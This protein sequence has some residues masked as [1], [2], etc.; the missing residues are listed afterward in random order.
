MNILK[1]FRSPYVTFFLTF[2]FLFSSCSQDGFQEQDEVLSKIDSSVFA[3]ESSTY[4]KNKR[5]L[6]D[7]QISDIG[8]N[9][10]IYLGELLVKQNGDRVFTLSELK[11]NVISKYPELTDH[12][13]ASDLIV[14]E[15]TSLN[16]NDFNLLI[17]KN[18]EL[19]NNPELLKDYVYQATLLTERYNN[20]NDFI[21][22]LNILETSARKDL[23]GVDLDTYLVFSSVYKNSTKF[24]FEDGNY[25]NYSINAKASRS[26][27]AAADGLAAGIGFLTLAVVTSGL[28]IAAGSGG[29]ATPAIVIVMELLGIG[30][31]AALSSAAVIIGVG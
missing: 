18:K 13:D 4:N 14:N 5:I 8:I 9:H 7:N 28:V 24:W 10:N 26:K 1:F 16:I 30:F 23:I 19:V 21:N 22:S 2:I 6:N 25:D 31:G 12:K 20:Y 11:N 29:L 3:R 17:D 15:S 27:V